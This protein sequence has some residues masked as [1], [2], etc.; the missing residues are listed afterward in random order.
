[1]HRP[2]K[3]RLITPD[4]APLPD[5]ETDD[6]PETGPLRRC[7]VTRERLA[8][9]AMIRFVIAPDAT[10]VPDLAERLPGRG[11]WLS[12]R[13]DVLET[14]RVRGA[15][16][17]SARRP[18]KVPAD[19]VADVATALAGRIRETLGLARRAG[20][21]VAGFAKAREWLAEGKAALVVQASDGSP[22]ERS[23]L[24]GANA[25]RLVALAPLDGATLGQIFGRD[26]AVHVA[27]GP[28]RLA[29]RLIAETARLAGVTGQELTKPTGAAGPVLSHGVPAGQD[30]AGG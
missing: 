27:V 18:V 25:G 14:A 30:N 12:A 11:I 24:L 4:L 10:V 1:M 23:R 7:A 21:A 3:G 6:E 15:F 16:A 2:P 20:L 9:D 5:E 26:H 29:E 13:G 28:G 19:L 8:K 22:G 17:K